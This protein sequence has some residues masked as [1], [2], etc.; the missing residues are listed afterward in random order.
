M[1]LVLDTG[2]IYAALDRG[3]PDHEPCISLVEGTHEQQIIPDPVLVELDYWLGEAGSLDTWL[4]FCQDVAAGVYALWPMN[5]TL[6]DEAAALQHR[7]HDHPIGFV[8]AAVF[9]TCVALGEDK[10]ATLD[11]RHFSVLR[12]QEGRSLRI[13]PE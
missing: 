9:C 8:D 5:A 10:V 2:V 7:F 11:R 6:L 12:T 3:D 4:Q 1:A 13:L